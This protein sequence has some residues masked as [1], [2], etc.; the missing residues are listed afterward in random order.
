MGAKLIVFTAAYPYGWGET[1][2]K[3]ELAFLSKR[4]HRIVI[5]P[6]QKP[7]VGKPRDT[8]SNVEIAEPFWSSARDRLIF[9][10]LGLASSRT[11]V[12]FLSEAFRAAA[13][14]GVSDPKAFLRILQSAIYR[15]AIENCA[16]VR[17][18]IGAPNETVAYCYWGSQMALPVL[19]LATAGVPCVVRYHGSDLYFSGWKAKRARE[20]GTYSPWREDIAR[21]TRMSVFISQHGMIYFRANWG[22]TLINPQRAVVRRL[23]VPDRG[24]NPRSAP[25]GSSPIVLVSCSSI[26]ENKRVYLIAALAKELSK[27]RNVIWHH[28]GFGEDPLLRQELDGKL[29]PR[30]NVFLEGLVHNEQIIHFYQKTNVSLFVN[31]S[32]SEGIPVSIMEAIS[33]GIPAVATNVGGTSEAVITGESG[34]LIDVDVACDTKKLASL[35]KDSIEPG[36]AIA[37]SNPREVWKERFESDKNFST[38]SLEVRSLLNA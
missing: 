22:Y 27:T 25:C 3:E 1:F 31:L 17:A 34:L 13:S 7:Q 23:G 20:R 10:S 21:A 24:I 30:L 16:A 5:V 11:W 12:L 29:P 36:G 28:F 32:L 18:A 8:P 35:I 15:R 19:T 6:F 38:F 26:D 2:L 37:R 9:Y 14:W 33:F 4:F